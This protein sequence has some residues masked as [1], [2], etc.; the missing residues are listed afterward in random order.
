MD[1][2]E[3]I[4]IAS[5]H[6]CILNLRSSELSIS[7]SPV[8]THQCYLQYS[9]LSVPLHHCV[10]PSAVP[11][12]FLAHS[13]N[14]HRSLISPS[15]LVIQAEQ[16][17]KLLVRTLK[18]TAP[19]TQRSGQVVEPG[20]LGANVFTPPLPFRAWSASLQRLEF[21]AV[22]SQWTRWWLQ[23]ILLQEILLD[24]DE[25]AGPAIFREFAHEGFGLL[26]EAFDSR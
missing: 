23:S 14:T 19:S 16:L 20:V 26:D 18:K 11:C 13:A 6:E 10:R 4:R 5:R 21:C 22:Q 25:G 9:T 17:S 1:V 12:P 3:E 7:G 8:P 24:V 15:A 2:S